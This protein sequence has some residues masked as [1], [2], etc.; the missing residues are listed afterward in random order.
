[1]QL[2]YLVLYNSSAFAVIYIYYLNNLKYVVSNVS[3]R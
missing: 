2:N 3:Y 1:M